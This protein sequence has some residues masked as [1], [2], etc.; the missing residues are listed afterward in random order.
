[1]EN[2]RIHYWIIGILFYLIGYVACYF[3]AR[4][5]NREQFP[6]SYN[7]GKVVF[8]FIFS[9]SSWIGFFVVLFSYIISKIKLPK[10]EPPKWL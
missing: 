8:G 7:W 10:G 9:L 2:N 5:S 1:M 4:K 3:M 6:E